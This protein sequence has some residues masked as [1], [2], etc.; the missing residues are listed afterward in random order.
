MEQWI[1]LLRGINVGGHHLVPMK[2]LRT[3]MEAAGFSS[4]KTYIQSG[5]IVCR[6]AGRPEDILETLMER[7]FGFRPWVLVLS[8]AELRAV[9]EANPFREGAGKT[10][11]FFFL[12]GD[13]ARMDRVLA[14]SLQAET[15]QFELRDNVFYLYA[16]E[17]IGRSRL[18]GRIGKVFPETRITARNRNTIEKLLDLARDS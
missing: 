4:V 6:F 17:G 9:A 10:V 2:E 7:H 14:Q 8:L 3:A 12:E 1:I 16:P 15:E 18:A 5:N 11:H 13:P